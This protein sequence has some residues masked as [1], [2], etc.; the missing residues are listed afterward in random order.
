MPASNVFGAMPHLSGQ[1][2]RYAPGMLPAMEGAG[3]PAGVPPLA[4][5]QPAPPPQAHRVSVERGCQKKTRLVWTPELHTRF[6]SAVE[7]I[8]LRTAVPRT[9]LQVPAARLS[10]V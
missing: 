8:G 9:I 2:P 5:A 7:Q 4:L 1:L 6:L 10:T 3:A